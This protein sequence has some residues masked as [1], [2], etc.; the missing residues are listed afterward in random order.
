VHFAGVRPT[1]PLREDHTKLMEALSEENIKRRL[2]QVEEEAKQLAFQMQM[3]K[4]KAD[5]QAKGSEENVSEHP[6]QVFDLNICFFMVDT[7]LQ[8]RDRILALVLS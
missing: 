4:F 3:L 2:K 1:M 6:D 7:V 5:E 8:K